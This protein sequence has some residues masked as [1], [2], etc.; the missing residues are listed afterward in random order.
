MEAERIHPAGP[1]SFLY[2]LSN[3][4]DV[5]DRFKADPTAV[6]NAFSLSSS[7]Q[8]VVKAAGDDLTSENIAK[9]ISFVQLEV[10]QRAEPMW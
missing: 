10:E 4:P 5:R 8:D 6:M 2:H 7:V 1:L 9:V 3:S